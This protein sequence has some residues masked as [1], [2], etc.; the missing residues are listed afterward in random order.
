MRCNNNSIGITSCKSNNSQIQNNFL[1][2]VKYHGMKIT[3]CT[4]TV[5][6]YHAITFGNHDSLGFLC[7][8]SVLASC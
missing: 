7:S 2:F 6:L 1:K 3:I 4:V 8:V 5:R